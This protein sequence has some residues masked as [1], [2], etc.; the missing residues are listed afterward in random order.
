[1]PNRQFDLD[2]FMMVIFGGAGD[3]SKKMLIPAL[4]HIHCDGDL[5]REAEIVGVGLPELSDD[6]YRSLL[7]DSIAAA[8]EESFR[9]DEWRAFANKV[10]YIPGDIDAEDTYRQLLLR[11]E[12]LAG[13]C[14]NN[15]I[16]YLAVPSQAMASIVGHLNALGLCRGTYNTKVIAEKPFGSDFESAVAL[17]QMLHGAFDENQ[18]FRIDYYLA[19]DT[20]QNLIFFR[21]ANPFF[22]RVWNSE[23]IDNVQVTVSE[24]IGIAQRG[25]FYEQT[26]IVRDM[27]QNHLLQLVSL[28][29][30][31]PPT[32]FESDSIRDEKVRVLRSIH[33]WNQ[34]GASPSAVRGQYAA[35]RIGEED[36]P[37]YRGEEGVDARSGTATYFAGRLFIDNRRWAGVP[38]Y[39][40]TG[41]RMSKDLTQVCIQFRKS[42][43]DLFGYPAGDLDANVL[44]LTLAPKEKINLTLGVKYP[45][46]SNQIYATDLGFS[47]FDAFQIRRH[48]PYE[49]LLIDCMKGDLTLFVRQDGT[50]AAWKIVDPL[51]ELWENSEPRDFPN[52][53]AGSWGPE[54]ADTL[55]AADGRRWLSF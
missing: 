36:V 32:G 42:P 15:I 19:I 3:L 14:G 12:E 17:N 26:G 8:E 40:R 23:H 44:Y 33:P 18:I 45:H 31:E 20:V 51:V 21:F 7:T 11:I 13:R 9:E 38:F 2:P 43:H 4:Y 53:S 34:N 28:I 52:Y 24:D 41:K 27:V 50:E 30:M 1:M 47:Y 39:I 10:S 54:A 55:L 6:Q 46:S 35:G 25:R 16:Y 29:A 48:P 22:E 49:K 37:G 5:P